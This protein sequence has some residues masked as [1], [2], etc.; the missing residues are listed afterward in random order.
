MLD[1]RYRCMSFQCRSLARLTQSCSSKVG[2]GRGGRTRRAKLKKSTVLPPRPRAVSGKPPRASTSRFASVVAFT[3]LHFTSF[4]F[5]NLRRHP[6]YSPLYR[7]RPQLPILD[8]TRSG[9]N[10]FNCGRERREGTSEVHKSTRWIGYRG[11]C[12]RRRGWVWVDR[13]VVLHR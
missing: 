7:P 6:H 10:Y 8:I 9:T 1:H 11:C 2:F 5:S 3:S 13:V 12:R 4:I